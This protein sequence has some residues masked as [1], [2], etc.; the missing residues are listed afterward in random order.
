MNSTGSG[1]EL[2]HGTAAAATGLGV[3]TFMVF[4]FAVPMMILT[5]AAALPRALPLIAVAVL[6][7]VLAAGWRGIRT[8]GRG[9]GRRRGS[10][11]HGRRTRRTSAGRSVHE[12]PS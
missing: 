3:L 1:P 8:A 12:A 10:G 7:A 5:V 11:T 6:G 2:L 4:P 9:I